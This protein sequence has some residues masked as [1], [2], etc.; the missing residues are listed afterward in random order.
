MGTLGTLATPARLGPGLRPSGR[1]RRRAPD[2]AQAPA[3]GFDPALQR[4]STGSPVPAAEVPRFGGGSDA[5][6]WRKYPEV[7]IWETAWRRL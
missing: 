1:Q 2:S 5:G 4:K 3:E 6:N 7:G